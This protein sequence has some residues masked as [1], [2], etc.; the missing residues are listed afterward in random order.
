MGVS[1]EEYADALAMALQGDDTML[2]I[3]TYHVDG[4]SEF[5]VLDM[6]DADDNTCRLS[7]KLQ[8][9]LE[10]SITALMDEAEELVRQEIR[11]RVVAHL[12]KDLKRDLREGLPAQPPQGEEMFMVF[13]RQHAMKYREF[14]EVFE[15]AA[16]WFK[17]IPGKGWCAARLHQT[18][19]RAKAC[20]TELIG[21]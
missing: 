11:Q 6:S 18:A 15:I 13:M 3:V 1:R 21:E 20:A 2:P 5:Q 16:E 4:T 7:P 17:S 19:M 9:R 14:A 12:A 8:L 10:N